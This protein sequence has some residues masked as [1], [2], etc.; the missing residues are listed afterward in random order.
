[1]LHLI[2]F[3][4]ELTRIRLKLVMAL[5]IF[6]INE[7]SFTAINVATHAPTHALSSTP[8]EIFENSFIQ[9]AIIV[10]SVLLNKRFDFSTCFSCTEKKKEKKGEIETIKS[11]DNFYKKIL[12]WIL[13]T[14]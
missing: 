11:K 2:R 12:N 4:V 14:R 7:I 3:W 9:V 13:K 8:I 5:G 1:M 10:S 6:V